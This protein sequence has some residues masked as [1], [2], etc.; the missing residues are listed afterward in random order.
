MT[1]STQAPDT[2]AA[3]AGS[4]LIRQAAALIRRD[5]YNLWA[6][7]SSRPG[8]SLSSALCAVAGCDPATRHIPACEDLH[9][10]VAGYLYLAGLAGTGRD[11]LPRVVEAWEEYDPRSGPHGQDE[12]LA[13]LERAAAALELSETVGGNPRPV[14]EGILMAPTTAAGRL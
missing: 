14:T 2:G 7:A 4:R 8:H 3:G 5:G 13:V 1:V 11:Y 12:I 10:R 9:G 6:P